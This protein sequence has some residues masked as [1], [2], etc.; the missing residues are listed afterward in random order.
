VPYI[1][2]TNADEGTIFAYALTITSDAEYRA[3]VTTLSPTYAT[4]LLA[5]YPSTDFPTPKD[6]YNHLLRDVLFTCNARATVRA[7]SPRVKQ[8]YLYYFTHVAAIGKS[9]G[10]GAFH[11][12]ELPF[13]FGNFRDAFAFPTADEIV[14]SDAMIGYFT[15]FAKS[16]DPG[17]ATA[18]PAYTTA[19]DPHLVLEAPVVAS[20]ALD[21]K[22]C[23]ALAAL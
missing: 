22:H 21:Q 1:V 5:I 12:A 15:R 10:L 4:K 18:W 11:T 20:S 3:A 16:G 9:S 23:D 7:V 2:G 8:T 17:G 6:A 19:S 14:L 13:V